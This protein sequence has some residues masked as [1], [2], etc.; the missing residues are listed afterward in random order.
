MGA[1]V[2]IN[3]HK[4]SEEIFVFLFLDT[5]A[6]FHALLFLIYIY[7]YLLDGERVLHL[8]GHLTMAESLLF[9]LQ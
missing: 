3:G 8:Q 9:D 2:H 6:K 1:N 4:A 5:P 7:I